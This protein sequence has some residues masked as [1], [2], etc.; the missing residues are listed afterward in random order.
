MYLNGKRLGQHW[1]PAHLFALKEELIP[2][3]NQLVIEVVNSINNGLIGDA[4][5]PVQYRYSR[6]N[7]SRLPHAWMKPFAEAPLLEAGLIG[8]VV[9]QW[10]E[11]ER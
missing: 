9:L 8:P 3:T 2:G 11:L 7:I 1:H 10:A 4:N 5:Q 6:S